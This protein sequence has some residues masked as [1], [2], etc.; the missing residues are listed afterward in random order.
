MDL[1]GTEKKTMLSVEISIGSCPVYWK[2]KLLYS[3]SHLNFYCVSMCVQIDW[4]GS[5]ISVSIRQT[6][7]ITLSRTHLLQNIS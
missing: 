4:N 5:C 1:S 2:R 7:F 6:K 3:L